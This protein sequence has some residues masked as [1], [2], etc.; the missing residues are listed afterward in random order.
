MRV[1]T[2]LPGTPPN[3][4]TPSHPSPRT[5]VIARRTFTEVARTASM[6]LTAVLLVLAAAGVTLWAGSR[7]DVADPT[8]LDTV[9]VLAGILPPLLST[10]LYVG[11]PLTRD[12]TNGTVTCLIATAAD[13][14]EAVHGAALA[15]Y[16]PGLPLML[17]VPIAVEVAGGHTGTVTFPLV[18][19]ALGLTPAV[20]WMLTTLTI[21]L[22][23]VYGPET[24][25][26]PLWLIAVLV[27]MGVP[28]GS[29]LGAVS[30]ASWAFL[31]LY[32]AG[33]GC[34]ALAVWGT[35]PLLTRQRVALAR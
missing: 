18:I 22:A 23:V 34:L 35:S 11:S 5:G 8:M 6:R 1:T 16:L 19:A 3:G 32:A 25:L 24:A 4:M 14:R 30:V 21:R 9:A 20:G 26:V 2:Q 28:A 15:I 7:R 31:A 33:A 29:L 27:L 12:L 10:L 17:A 13:P